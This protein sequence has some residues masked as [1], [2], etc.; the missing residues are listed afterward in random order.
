MLLLSVL[1]VVVL[2]L[3]RGGVVLVDERVLALDAVFIHLVE[4]G[5][6][7]S[8]VG[9]QGVGAGPGEVLAD[10]DAEHLQA[11]GLRSHGVGGD[12]PAANAEGVGQCELIV[13]LLVA[14]DGGQAEG[15]QGETFAG[16]LGHDNVAKGLEGVGQVVRGAGEVVHDG[17][18]A[19]LAQPDQ[20]VVLADDLA[21]SL[22]EVESE[23]RLVGTEVVDVEDELLGEI[24]G[25]A[26]DDPADA[27][28]DE[29]VLQSPRL[30]HT[31]TPIPS[32]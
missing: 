28:V 18:V 4:H 11:V 32:R 1:G 26:P 31:H 3:A 21:G 10:D 16:L 20:L 25:G 23:G 17:A 27:G 24:L 7:L 2:G 12:D 29:T 22:G 5:G 15:D 13:V 19:L 8:D 9:D 6:R 30:A 14:V